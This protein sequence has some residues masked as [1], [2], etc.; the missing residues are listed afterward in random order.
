MI[1]GLEKKSYLMD[2]FNSIKESEYKKKIT[3]E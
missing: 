1:T 2:D 3:V